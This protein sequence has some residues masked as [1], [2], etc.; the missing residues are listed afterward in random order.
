MEWITSYIKDVVK[1]SNKEA[2]D[3]AKEV[4]KTWA[5]LENVDAIIYNVSSN[6]NN[7]STARYLSIE[8]DKKWY[9]YKLVIKHGLLEVG[10]TDK[11]YWASLK[12]VDANNI[13]LGNEEVLNKRSE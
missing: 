13:N 10:K 7:D 3:K 5:Y 1:S 8:N 6:R 2:L 4:I 12:R 9:L 11:V